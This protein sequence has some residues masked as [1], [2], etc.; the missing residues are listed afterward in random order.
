MLKFS[1]GT[2]CFQ[3]FSCFTLFIYCRW[4]LLKNVFY[5]HHSSCILR[6]KVGELTFFQYLFYLMNE[7]LVCCRKFWIFPPYFRS[8]ISCRFLAFIIALKMISWIFLYHVFSYSLVELETKPS[9][10][11]GINNYLSQEELILSDP[12]IYS[13][14]L[15][16]CTLNM[17]LCFDRLAGLTFT[18]QLKWELYIYIYV[19]LSSF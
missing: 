14:M 3:N 4:F 17:A 2:A 12:E 1:C 5:R 18:P 8:S 9:R 7:I 6:F 13:N 11:G 16:G 15:N 10:G 19:R